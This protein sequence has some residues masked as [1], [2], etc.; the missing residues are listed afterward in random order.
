VV[1]SAGE[2]VPVNMTASIIYDGG[3]EMATVGIFSDL[4]DRIRIEQRLLQAQ[5]E[6]KQREQQ[7]MIAELAGAAAHELNQPLT[8]IIGYA[9]LIQKTANLSDRHT[10]YTD[11]IVTEAERM[12]EIVRKIGRITHYET[13]NYVGSANIVDLNKSVEASESAPVPAFLS[14]Y[15]D[16]STARITLDEIAASHES[17]M[18]AKAEKLELAREGKSKANSE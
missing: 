3:R 6:L 13:V 18:H 2:L 11:T 9:Q 8:S 10:R 16:E 17:E 1:T 15:E 4:R 12:S 5:E 14:D 7:S